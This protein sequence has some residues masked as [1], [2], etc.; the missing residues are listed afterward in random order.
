MT[1]STAYVSAATNRF[2]QAA[3]ISPAS[4]VAFGTSRLIALWSLAEVDSGIHETLPGHEGLVTCVRFTSEQAFW[5]ISSKKQAHSQSVSCLCLFEDCLVTGSSDATVKVWRLENGPN[6]LSGKAISPRLGVEP[7]SRFERFDSISVVLVITPTFAIAIVLAIS[8]TDGNV[9]LWLRSSGDSFIHS[10]ALAGHEDWVRGLA[11]RFPSP[12]GQSLILASAS[13]DST[14][15]LWNIDRDVSENVRQDT[16]SRELKDELLDNFEASLGDIGDAE[17]GGRQMSLKR[18]ILTVKS[19]HARHVASFSFITPRLLRRVSSLQRFSVTFDALLVGHEAGVTALKWRQTRSSDSV[20]T[21]LSTSTD[22][23]VILWSPATTITRTDDESN[24]IWIN[25][26]RFGDIGGQR[27][28][29]FVGGAWAQD[30]TESLSWGWA[31]GWRRWRCNAHT[32][33]EEMWQEIGAIS[34]HRGPVKGLAWSPGGEYLISAGLDQ[35]SRIHA[36][37]RE[38]GTNQV[39]WHEVARPQV[40]GYD[41]IDAVFVN[42]LKFVSIADEKVARVFE[43]PRGF[44]GMINCLHI[45]EFAENGSDRPIAANV[46]PLGLSNKPVA[47]T[48]PDTSVVD[49]SRQPF[50]GDLAAST[51]WPEIEKVF[52][53]GYELI[54]L[55]IS[56]SRRLVA[57]ACKATA[58]DHAVIRI[59]D[60]DT[61]RLV[62]QPLVG[63]TLT[64]TR[65]MF[66]PDDR[67]LLSVSRD[68]S[69]RLFETQ[70]GVGYVP[71]AADKSH[72]RIIWDCAWSMEG[73]IFATASRDKTVKIWGCEKDGRW[74]A[75]TTVRTESA[76]TAIDFTGRDVHGRR[77][78]AI[79]LETGEVMVYVNTIE[80]TVWQLAMSRSMHVDHINRLA[81]RP[82]DNGTSTELASCSED[83]TLKILKVQVAMD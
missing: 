10:A 67:Y 79:G 18:H 25:R 11:F 57:T 65:V 36:P 44:V 55:G 43:A 46:P 23:S 58:L 20:P 51:L 76:A 17:E 5:K 53:H 45:A 28:G 1:I 52:G 6:N 47:D 50:E 60:T 4:L 61:F 73:D 3:D 27:F 41:L 70:D 62:G 71:V 31:G 63:H 80:D 14:I 19:D 37:I 21:L 64:V 39:H 40:H 13:Q 2:S 35:T 9:N 81:W 33:G 78:L 59:Y 74:S 22:S 34:G 56:H 24:T 38:V 16:A 42:P 69:W 30:G 83:G 66:S 32:E 68:R 12:P 75:I 8:G 48:T 77:R 26:Q 29:G 15:R 49:Y 7:P 82:N 72:G 54:T